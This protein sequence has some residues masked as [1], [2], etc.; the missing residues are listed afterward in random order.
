[1]PR[2]TT[3][4]LLRIASFA[5]AL[6]VLSFLCFGAFY[7]L[8]YHWS[9]RPV[10]NYWRLFVQGWFATLAIAALALP[11]STVLGLA[12]ALARRSDILPLRDAARIWVEVTRGTPL[13]VQ[14]WVYFY[15]FGQALSVTNR[16]V[17]GPLILA[18]FSAAYLSEIIRGGIEGIGKSQLESARAIGL[19]PAQTYRHVI[20]PQAIR[21]ILPA[22][23][24]QFASLIKD[25]S[26]LSIIG[27]SE[28]AMAA[29][30]V[31]S[32]TYSP[33]ESYLP[34]ALGYLLL[35]LPIMLWSHRYAARLRFET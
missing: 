33:F 2:A 26:L 3:H 34:V 15:V 35:T 32:F 5:G 14:I 23:V 8:D 4:T 27:I 6:L 19:T 30:E 10:A 9:W 18:G 25:S 11:V 7:L 24:G 13:L 20:F 31:N 17:L 1:M 29:G 22:L 28:L 21:N 16:Y 12:L